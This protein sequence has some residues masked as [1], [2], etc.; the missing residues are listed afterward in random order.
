MKKKKKKKD[1]FPGLILDQGTMYLCT[2]QK[3]LHIFSYF[4]EQYT[5]ST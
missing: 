3:F 4:L 5:E 1:Q 2:M